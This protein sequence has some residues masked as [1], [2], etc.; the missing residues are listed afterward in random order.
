MAPARG[1]VIGID[2]GDRR[3]GV[4]LS[5]EGR[6]IARALQT[7]PRRRGREADAEVVSAIC[8]L[9]KTHE[10]THLVIG[11]PLRLNGREGIQTQKV[12]R[13]IELLSAHTTLTISKWDERL[14]TTSAE[15]SLREAGLRGAQQRAK[16]DQVAAA[17]I[18]QGWLDATQASTTP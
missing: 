10:V 14:T 12:A 9:I 6:L 17:F 16:V 1:R 11:W 18:L 7:I 3:V 8:S 4:S 13:F 2:Y 5:D 15:R